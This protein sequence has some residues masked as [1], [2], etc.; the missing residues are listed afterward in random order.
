METDMIFRNE[1]KKIRLIF[2]I[3]FLIALLNPAILYAKMVTQL[4]PTFTITEEYTDNYFRTQNDK[5]DEYTT[6]IGLGFSL[7]FLEKKR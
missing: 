3:F 6:T 4:V 2:T 7:G 5:F 1:K